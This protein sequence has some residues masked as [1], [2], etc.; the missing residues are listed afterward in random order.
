MKL[1]FALLAI[2][3]VACGTPKDVTNEAPATDMNENSFSRPSKPLAPFFTAYSPKGEWIVNIEFE[4]K[5]AFEHKTRGVKF[6]V[7]APEAVAV[8][9]NGL[10]YTV[11][12]DRGDQFVLTIYEELCGKNEWGRKALV[13]GLQNGVRTEESVCGYY[14]ESANEKKRA[15]FFVEEVNGK[16]ASEYFGD[17]EVPRAEFNVES[18]SV[19]GVF[20]CRRF[21]GAFNDQQETLSIS[22]ITAPNLDCYEGPLTTRFMMAVEKSEMH[23]QDKNS[24]IHFK[25]NSIEFVLHKLD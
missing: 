11:N 25:S 2:G 13:S 9:P 19:S 15:L 7:P 17:E 23:V 12:F 22:F 8:S 6:S 4:G 21:G 14:K 20:G 10:S 1:L 5:L 18:G 3:M 24:R 16:S